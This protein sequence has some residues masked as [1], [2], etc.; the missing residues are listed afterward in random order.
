MTL[1]LTLCTCSI[2]SKLFGAFMGL[3][4]TVMWAACPWKCFSDEVRSCVSNCHD[5][6]QQMHV[7]KVKTRM[8]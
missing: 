4:V 5:M 8:S 6:H 2:D 3:N 1:L 7:K